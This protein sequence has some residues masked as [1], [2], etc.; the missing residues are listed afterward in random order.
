MNQKP[1]EIARIFLE[2]NTA[3]ALI[4][5][6]FAKNKLN[7]LSILHPML[8]RTFYPQ[9]GVEVKLFINQKD[10]VYR[11]NIKATSNVAETFGGITIDELNYDGYNINDERV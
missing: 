8:N 7:Q 2:G 10:N 11:I 4:W 3:V 5:L 6:G 9:N 1:S